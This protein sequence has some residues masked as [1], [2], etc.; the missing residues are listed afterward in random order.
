MAALWRPAL[1]AGL[2]LAIIL[3]WKRWLDMT[4][5]KDSHLVWLLTSITIG[6]LVYCGAV[7]L[8]WRIAGKPM[9][10]ESTVLKVIKAKVLSTRLKQISV[11]GG[12]G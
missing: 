2:M 12:R 10:A 1:G 4:E 11:R 6:A 8:L 5:F 3:T 7:L 9:G